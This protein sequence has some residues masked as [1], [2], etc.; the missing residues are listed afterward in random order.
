[1]IYIFNNLTSKIEPA[2]KIINKS[3]ANCKKL[4][5]NSYKNMFLS[6]TLS[7]TSPKVKKD[8]FFFTVIFVKTNRKFKLIVFPYQEP[9]FSSGTRSI[10]RLH[11]LQNFKC[12]FSSKTISYLYVLFVILNAQIRLILIEFHLLRKQLTTL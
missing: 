12:V 11:Q 8:L 4:I 7:K 1:M 6:T 9:L 2:D 5:Q 10:S 3:E